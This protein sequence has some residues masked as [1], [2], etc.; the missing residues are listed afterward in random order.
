MVAKAC[1]TSDCR[2][3]SACT[4]MTTWPIWLASTRASVVS[5]KGGESKMTIRSG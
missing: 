2:V 1:C 5:S 3:L 4:T